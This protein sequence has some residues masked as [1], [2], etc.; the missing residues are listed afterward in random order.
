MLS[1]WALRETKNHLVAIVDEGQSRIA[2]ASDLATQVRIGV[3]AVL[4]MMIITDPAHAKIAMDKGMAAK[5]RFFQGRDR[6]R[7]LAKSDPEA[8]QLVNTRSA[9]HGRPASV[10]RPTGLPEAS[11]SSKSPISEM[12]G[13]S[14]DS[15]PGIESQPKRAAAATSGACATP[16]A[17]GAAPPTDMDPP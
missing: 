4:T 6:L 15:R 13:S 17:E 7:E 16:I 11:T 14:G 8:E 2:L 10:D 12:T 5:E 9:T 1:L 3:E